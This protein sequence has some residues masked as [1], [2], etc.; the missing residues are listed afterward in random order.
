MYGTINLDENEMELVANAATPYRVKQ[1]FNIDIMKEFMNAEQDGYATVVGIL[2]QLT[3]V[4]N[5]QA[6]KV[7]MNKINQETFLLWCENIEAMAIL[8][9]AEEIIAIYQ[10]NQKTTSKPK[11]NNE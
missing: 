9:H 10:G 11:K 7:D 8:N 5:C 4:M 6:L 2:P 1:I 3:Y